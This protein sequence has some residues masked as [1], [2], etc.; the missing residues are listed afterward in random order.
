LYRDSQDNSAD[1]TNY[2]EIWIRFP[3]LS[4]QG[5]HR[6]WVPSSLLL[7][8]RYFSTHLPLQST[9]WNRGVMPH[10]VHLRQDCNNSKFVIFQE[11]MLKFSKCYN[12]LWVQ[13]RHYCSP[14]ASFSNYVMTL[15][16]LKVSLQTFLS[17]PITHKCQIL[18]CNILVANER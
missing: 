13:I 6:L 1:E 12:F 16:L 5:P 4:P 15:Y 7:N 8:G 17:I 18:S 3:V 14:A 10:I 2:R 9:L 11:K